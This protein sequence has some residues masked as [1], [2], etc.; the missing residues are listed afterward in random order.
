MRRFVYM[1]AQDGRD[2]LKVSHFLSFSV[3]WDIKRRERRERRGVFHHRGHREH[4]ERGGLW[5]VVGRLR[6]PDF[7]YE[8][9]SLKVSHF[10]SFSV[11]WDIK[12][13]ERRGVFR[14]RGHREHGGLLVVVG[15]LRPPDFGYERAFFLK[16]SHFLSFSVIW[17][18]GATWR[19]RGRGGLQTG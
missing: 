19:G 11:I 13:R 7:G 6:P 8:R 2:F 3:I 9:D 1:D 15:R 16:V 10:L 12:R 4:G 14:H 17:G 18:K 5:V